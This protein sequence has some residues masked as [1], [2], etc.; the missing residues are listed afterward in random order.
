MERI[1]QFYNELKEKHLDKTV[2]IIGHRATQYG[3]DTLIN[4][5]TLEELLS[6]PFKWQPYWE[7]EF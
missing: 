2:L 7:Y 4:H 5:K 1:H 3:L 6:I